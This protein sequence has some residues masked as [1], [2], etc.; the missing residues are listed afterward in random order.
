MAHND[1]RAELP[2]RRAADA[3]DGASPAVAEATH[4]EPMTDTARANARRGSDGVIGPNAIIRM[5]EA[6]REQA[7]E[8]ATVAVFERAGLG[9]YLA[10]PPS[11][12]VRE[13]EVAAVHT[14]LRLELGPPRARRAARLAGEKTG[15]YLLAHR[16]PRAVQRVLRILPAPL[17]S[18]VLLAAIG[19]NAWTFCGSGRFRAAAGSPVRVAIAGNPL[20]RDA[21]G[22]ATAC[23]FYAGTFERLFGA[24]VH[25]GATVREVQCE[26][27]GDAACVFEIRWPGRR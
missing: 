9:A 2:G 16:I 24:L 27:R 10:T 25:R 13:T 23:D 4:G 14:A 11:A 6:L 22:D 19:R 3:P 12:M 1:D 18:R 15:D 21:P 17:A 20:C 8:A 7:G 5:A 26:S